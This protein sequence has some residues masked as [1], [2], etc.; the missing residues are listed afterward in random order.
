MRSWDVCMATRI[1]LYPQ[2][3]TKLEKALM[4]DLKGDKI[5]LYER[6]FEIDL[7]LSDSLNIEEGYIY[8]GYMLFNDRIPL[9]ELE[10]SFPA[11]PS[12]MGVVTDEEGDPIEGAEVYVYYAGTDIL[13]ASTV[14][15]ENGFYKVDVP[16]EK[17]YD[18]IIIKKGVIAGKV[19]VSGKV[20]VAVRENDIIDDR[21][22]AYLDSEGFVRAGDRWYY[23]AVLRLAEGGKIY[24][25]VYNRKTLEPVPNVKVIAKLGQYENYGV[26]DENGYYEIPVPR[27]EWELEARKP[28]FKPAKGLKAVI[29][30][31]YR[32]D[33]YLDPA[34]ID[35]YVWDA[36]ESTSTGLL[37]P[38]VGAKV[39]IG[40][41][42]AETDEYGHF[43]VETETGE[44]EVIIEAPRYKILKTKI[45]VVEGETYNF[46][47]WKVSA[48]DDRFTANFTK[49]GLATYL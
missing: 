12:I 13:V 34:K 17:E 42:T 29:Q 27:G 28:G 33:I 2:L 9:K 41:V 24:G 18:V 15:D 32:Q 38:V 36:I 47:L 3:F 26:S 49:D 20:R 37:K 8:P 19:F 30:S 11:N 5:T 43:W 22:R 44:Q 48:Y 6:P 10:V 23:V 7:H 21:C 4:M 46:Y 14:T 40:G 16:S 1:K 45:N 25:Y 35:G 31:N 39:T